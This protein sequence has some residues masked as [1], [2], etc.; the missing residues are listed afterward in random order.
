MGV[1][2][3]FTSRHLARSLVCSLSVCRDHCCTILLHH[4]S[5]FLA[6]VTPNSTCFISY[7][8]SK[9]RYTLHTARKH[10]CLRIGIKCLTKKDAKW[11]AKQPDEM[12][13]RWTS[14]CLKDFTTGAYT[15]SVSRQL[16]IRTL[17]RTY[18]SDIPSPATN[19]R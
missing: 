3:T 15:H 19:D 12:T 10:Q 16:V 4:P 14:L 5:I 7:A 13:R 6:G 8:E 18:S 17:P 9:A 2:C 1:D 11:H